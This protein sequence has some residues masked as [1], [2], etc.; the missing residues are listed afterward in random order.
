MADEKS[1]LCSNTT[2]CKFIK[3]NRKNQAARKRH[4]SDD[5]KRKSCCAVKYGFE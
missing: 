5:E 3:R 2:V 4:V 1:E